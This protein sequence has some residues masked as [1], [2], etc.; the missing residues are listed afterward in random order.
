MLL[1]PVLLLAAATAFPDP[2][3]SSAEI[4]AAK[5]C[6]A[7]TQGLT[8]LAA[9]GADSTAGLNA[10]LL[11]CAGG[12]LAPPAGTYRVDGT[13][14]VGSA[15][16][17]PARNRTLQLPPT[18]FHLAMGVELR[19]FANWSAATAP[20]V[21]VSGYRC[22]LTGEGGTVV[23]ENAAPLG[24]VHVGPGN[25]SVRA[26]IQFA[27]VGGIHISGRYAA[28]PLAP[29]SSATPPAMNFSDIDANPP[30]NASTSGYNQCGGW[31]GQVAS[32]GAGGSIGLCMDSSQPDSAGA[33]YQNT[34]RDVVIMAVDVGIYMGKWVN[35]N[36]ISNVQY[37]SIG[38]TSLWLEENSENTIE[39]GFTGGTFPGSPFPFPETFKEIIRGT[40][41]LYNWFS[42]VQGE[43]G[44]GRYFSFDNASE[45][46]TVLGHDNFAHGPVS[47]DPAFVY[48]NSGAVSASRTMHAPSIVCDGTSELRDLC[49]P[50]PIPAAAAVKLGGS[51]LRKRLEELRQL[52]AEGLITAAEAEAARHQALGLL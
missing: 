1:Q 44:R 11:A 9:V 12:M 20:V 22:R 25:R 23:S 5:S 48:I 50:H 24:V 33:A 37:I 51:E 31:P 2:A 45:M 30:W 49:K 43:P 36:Q 38:T 29:G 42:G 35:A 7:A 16:D 41:S 26:S 32:F 28:E 39:G 18:H 17:D 47:L 40:A 34:V 52:E 13:V 10:A 8:G 3:L 21:R 19:R 27:Y 15:A 4:S 6:A 14:T 46:N